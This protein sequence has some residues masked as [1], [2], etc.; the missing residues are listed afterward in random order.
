M[1][2]SSGISHSLYN[3]RQ[4]FAVTFG[5]PVVTPESTQALQKVQQQIAAFI[6]RLPRIST[7]HE[8]LS[9]ALKELPEELFG[10]TGYLA[11]CEA[12]RKAI[13]CRNGN[14]MSPIE[15][16][17]K[18]APESLR[19]IRATLGERIFNA[20]I[21]CQNSDGLKP[22]DLAT[23]FNPKALKEM[24]KSLGEAFKKAILA[25]NGNGD[26]RLIDI[27]TANNHESLEV[28]RTVLGQ[29][30]FNEVILRKNSD[31]MKPI[32]L[33]AEHNHESLRLMAESLG[34]ENFN[35]AILSKEDS[36]MR[37]IDHAIQT[38]EALQFMKESLGNEAFKKAILAGNEH[39]HRLI[40]SAVSY[41]R[42]F[43]LMLGSFDD[44]ELCGFLTKNFE[45]GKFLGTEWQERFKAYDEVLFGAVKRLMSET[46]KISDAKAMALY[47]SSN[48]YPYDSPPQYVTDIYNTLVARNTGI[49]KL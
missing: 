12:F 40:D 48:K 8:L 38:P 43:G 17:A 10:H 45:R 22:I 35:T 7:N 27:A 19:L 23:K 36:R 34:K 33:A 2:N 14:D 18:S 44:V 20:A 28:M 41:P 46:P 37:A 25:K 24:Q 11:D 13:L 9:N 5:M 31:D 1:A 4:R 21:L 30:R 49:V 3:Q 42:S 29:E 26:D 39:G 32:D 16:A 6:A 47:E 15:N